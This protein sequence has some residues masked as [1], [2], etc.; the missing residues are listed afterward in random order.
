MS[1][2]GLIQIPQ[3]EVTGRIDEAFELERPNAS[4]D[5]APVTPGRAYSSIEVQDIVS[6]ALA[7]HEEKI[8]D[9]KIKKQGRRQ[10]KKKDDTR[11][12]L[13][14]TLIGLKVFWTVVVSFCVIATGFKLMILS[15]AILLALIGTLALSQLSTIVAKW[16]FAD[17]AENHTVE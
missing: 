12:G 16:W 17:N 1:D 10:I 9:R 11:H 3:E 13:T 2:E 4:I 14:Y 15:D 8:E 6:T 5:I 7:E